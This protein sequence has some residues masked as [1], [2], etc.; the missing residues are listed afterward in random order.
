MS[1]LQK[2]LIRDYLLWEMLSA[3]G[4]LINIPQIVVQIVVKPLSGPK[5]GL[6]LGDITIKKFFVNF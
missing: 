2:G 4:V 1:E 6:G 5:Q 3:G